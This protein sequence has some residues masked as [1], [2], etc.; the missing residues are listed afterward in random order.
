MFSFEFQR[1]FENENLQNN[2]KQPFLLE[3]FIENIK[4]EKESELRN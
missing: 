1:S 2:L 3:T 4:T